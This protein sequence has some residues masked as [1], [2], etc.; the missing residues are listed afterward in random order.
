MAVRQYQQ[1][2]SAAFDQSKYLS[3]LKLS[4]KAEKSLRNLFLEQYSDSLHGSE[5]NSTL[6]LGMP[7][8]SVIATAGRKHELSWDTYR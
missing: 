7:D 6:S 1:A 3:A 8:A 2:T 4:V 5:L